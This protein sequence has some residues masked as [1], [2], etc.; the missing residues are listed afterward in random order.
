MDSEVV[1]AAVVE[2]AVTLSVAVPYCMHVVFVVADTGASSVEA[3]KVRRRRRRRGR[4]R[5]VY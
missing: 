4:R 5:R 2:A 1:A 3:S